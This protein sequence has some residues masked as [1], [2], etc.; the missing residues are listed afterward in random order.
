MKKAFT[1][2]EILVVIAII[3]ILMAVLTA[4]FMNAPKKAQLAKCR[5]L[6]S[7]TATV[8]TVMFDDRGI[9]PEALRNNSR[10]SEQGLDRETGYPLAKAGMALTSNNGKLS[11]LDRF[12]VVTPWAQDVIKKM[13]KDSNDESRAVP[14]GGKIKD[15]RLRC[16]VDLDGDGV[17][18]DAAV[19][20][21]NVKIRATA[22]V[23]CCGADGVIESYT[24]G[25]R[26]DDVYSWDVGK[27]RNVN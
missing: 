26:A 4:T 25:R 10:L 13:N 6:V 27:A 23:W 19:G 24:D 5:E 9:W 18:D 7:N 21:E 2:V 3:G 11:G 1:L 15:H 20:G 12:G 8:L 22:A 17:I 14:S 16:A